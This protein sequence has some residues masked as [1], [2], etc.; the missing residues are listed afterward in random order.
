MDEFRFYRWLF[1]AAA[2]YNAIW[3]VVM[4]LAPNFL[5]EQLGMPI[6][7]Y[8]SLWQCIGMMVG[9][10]AIGYWLIARDPVRYGAF[11]WIGFLGKLFGPI[12]FVMS[13]VKGDLPWSFG[14]I[15][16]ANDVIW[17]VPF[18]MFLV[19]ISRIERERKIV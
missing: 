4:V 1:Y 2:V 18:A 6:P 16:V 14:W 5:F 3:G 8:P 12:G 19:K 15:N 17:L 13:A 11:A 10:Y 7:N 9:V